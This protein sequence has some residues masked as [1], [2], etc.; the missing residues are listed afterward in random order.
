MP[1]YTMSCFKLPVSLCKRIES[2]LTRFWWDSTAEKKKMC[3]MAWSKMTKSKRD[4]GLGFKVITNFNDA[5][6]SKVSWQ[7]L[8]SPNCLLAK[9][10]L[11]KYCSASSFPDC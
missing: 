1:T 11:G 2:A 6:L 8:T 9:I 10:V 7:I 4:G 5:L 3:W